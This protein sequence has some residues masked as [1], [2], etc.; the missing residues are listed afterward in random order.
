M[1]RTTLIMVGAI[2]LSGAAFA[3]SGGPPPGGPPPHPGFR[4]GPGGPGFRMGPQKVVTGAPYS[5][6]VSESSVRTLTDGNTIQ[7][8]T[9][10]HV[11]R[12]SQG[13]MY[14]Q[15][16]ITGGPL[17][18]NGPTTM[19]FI[20]D[21]VGGYVY[22]LNATTKIA[23]RRPI[24]TPPSGSNPPSGSGGN[25]PNGGGHNRPGGNNIVTTDLGTQAV[26]GVNAQGK[27]VTHTTPAGAVGNAQPIV[28]TTETW[29]SPDLQVV[30]SSTRTDP[31]VGKS[32]YTLNNIQRGDP[33]PSLFQVPSDYTIQD[34]SQNPRGGGAPRFRRPPHQ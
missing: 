14:D 21:P 22:S 31:Q 16:T 30:V 33:D 29:Y 17:G 26:N 2:L 24:K 5:A 1:T 6:D 13:R 20:S 11:A 27:R 23:T 18:S 34:A 9:T 32:S 4:G 8:T 12:D 28:S 15:Q 25:P 19:T 3:Q 10:G 7:H